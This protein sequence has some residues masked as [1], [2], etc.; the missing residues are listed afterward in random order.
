MGHQK[1]ALFL[2]FL[3]WAH[4]AIHQMSGRRGLGLREHP[5]QEERVDLQSKQRLLLTRACLGTAGMPLTW[6]GRTRRELRRRDADH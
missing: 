1:S 5:E 6:A 4:Q 3:F 2:D